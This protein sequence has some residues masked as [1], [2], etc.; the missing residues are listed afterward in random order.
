M[1]IRKPILIKRD[2]H[3]EFQPQCCAP[4]TSWNPQAWH[5]IKPTQTSPVI[6]MRDSDLLLQP[7][8]AIHSLN[9]QE[10]ARSRIDY[11]CSWEGIS[12]LS[13]QRLSEPLSRPKTF[14][15]C[16]KGCLKSWS[17]KTRFKGEKR[18]TPWSSWW[19]YTNETL[20]VTTIEVKLIVTW[21]L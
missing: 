15:S 4:L 14:L 12:W 1:P 3:H 2:N 18:S 8:T 11:L 16:L 7:S 17:W 21:C 10:T 13:S 20:G 19:L 6:G 9:T 5:S